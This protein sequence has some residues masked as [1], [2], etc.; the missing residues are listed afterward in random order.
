MKK[1][2]VHCPVCEGKFNDSAKVESIIE[3]PCCGNSL[4]VAKVTEKVVKIMPFSLDFNS[5]GKGSLDYDS[6]DDDD[7][8]EEECEGD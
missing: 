7:D 4:Y 8:C 3:C 2:N 1:I 6:E 5:N